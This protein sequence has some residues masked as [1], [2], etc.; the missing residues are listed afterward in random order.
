[1]YQVADSNWWPK[2]ARVG[3]ISSIDFA[4]VKAVL[5]VTPVLASE[6]NTVVE[7]LALFPNAVANSCKVSND[8]G[9]APTRL[10]TALLT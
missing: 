9:A 7:K 3:N 2:V 5:A 8:A 6:F 4:V 10:D 1:M